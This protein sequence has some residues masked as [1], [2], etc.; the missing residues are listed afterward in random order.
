M[1]QQLNLFNRG[2]LRDEGG[3]IDEVSGNRVPIG[4]TKKG[5]RDDI[6][7]N[8]SEG[9]FVFPEDVTRY[10]G[11]EKLMQ[12]RQEAKMG[13]KQMEAMGQM[14]NSEEAV[15]PDDLPF[16][17]AD[18]IIVGGPEEKD[19]Y[20]GG[21]MNYQEGGFVPASAFREPTYANPQS[22]PATATSGYV[23]TFVGEGVTRRT[24]TGSPAPSVIASEAVDSIIQMKQYVN[25]AGDIINL[26]FIAGQ[27]VYP[28]PAG[29]RPLDPADA[30]DETTEEVN[31][32]LQEIPS[33]PRDS[34]PEDTFIKNA[35]TAAGSWTNAPLDMYIKEAKKFT[36]GTSSIVTGIMGALAGPV[37]G[38]FTYLA[39]RDQKR[40]IRA[41]IDSRMRTAT[42][43]QLKELQDI[44]DA[45]E[46]KGNQT[47]IV[48]KVSAFISSIFAPQDQKQ[49]AVNTAT[50][51]LATP[52]ETNASSQIQKTAEGAA[53]EVPISSVAQAEAA[54]GPPLGTTVSTG[55]G[56]EP[57][58]PLAAPPTPISTQFAT[59]P[60]MIDSFTQD[61]A[62]EIARLSPVSPQQQQ[63]QAPTGLPQT[64]TISPIYTDE[65]F[66]QYNKSGFTRPAPVP[67]PPTTPDTSPISIPFTG[68]GTRPSSPR[69]GYES[70]QDVQTSVAP[71]LA[72]QVQGTPAFYDPPR[73]VTATLMPTSPAQPKLDPID[74]MA[75]FSPRLGNRV[76][77]SRE[78]VIK[79]ITTTPPKP[80][81]FNFSK[82]PAIASVPKEPFGA[83]LDPFPTVPKGERSDIVPTELLRPIN[84]F[85]PSEFSSAVTHFY[86]TGY[87]PFR[88]GTGFG[89]EPPVPL[90]NL[91]TPTPSMGFGQEPPV[92][93][94]DIPTPAPSLAPDISLRP[95]ARPTDVT[96]VTEPTTTTTGVPRTTA[97]TATAQQRT[98][99]TTSG[100]A[101]SEAATAAKAALIDADPSGDRE[102]EINR[103]E[104]SGYIG[105]T[106]GGIATGKIAGDGQVSGVVANEDGTVAKTEDGMT[107]YRD[108]NGVE[109][110]R[111]VFG[112][113]QTTDGED[114]DGPANG[115][116]G[117]DTGD[118][119]DTGGCV[120]ATHA[121]A[122]GAFHTSDKAN[123]VEWC[124]N[125]LHNKWW[126]EI[127]RR[128]YRYLGRKHISNGT[129]ET[130]YKEFKECIEWA[131]GKRPFDIKIVSR[132]LY[133]V[134]QTFIVGLFVREN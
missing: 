124:K 106:I 59:E 51:D 29:Y 62:P 84:P 126:G 105:S 65:D 95:V 101:A 18:L 9:E 60:S 11:L 43:Q 107:I 22:P 24:V 37:L 49:K 69:F 26:P 127:M 112:N 79:P 99:S 64:T 102:R 119:E 104:N 98:T 129:A 88:S 89:Q 93:L 120:I 133:R 128:G 33:D 87:Q 39:T 96:S 66:N 55:F 17:M 91:S 32:L 70:G 56:Q 23:P 48:G 110:T 103:T 21:S 35:F 85:T 10:I 82:D 5:V 74:E 16:G 83:P 3:E 118:S 97:T 54:M 77:S 63:F 7:V 19:A 90:A 15:I 25:D 131:N 46:G 115:H 132:Y 53:V 36:N 125:N 71:Y 30:V 108:S 67:K 52:V 114:Y 41:T 122:S 50:T 121:V 31:E 111:N 8:I 80:S 40:K 94:A 100:V 78:A 6:D 109:Y 13:L 58:A 12:L 42:G 123:A 81:F 57:P 134:T 1:Q 116:K 61:V 72:G 117:N 86:G 45:L 44:K 75:T 76:T 27:P 38:S 14:G 2:G 92:P 20:M 130:V 34:R 4:G 47:S 113:L 28:I 73:D 68:T